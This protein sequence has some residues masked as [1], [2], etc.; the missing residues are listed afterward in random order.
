VWRDPAQHQQG[1]SAALTSSPP[2]NTKQQRISSQLTLFHHYHYTMATST[3]D[4]ISSRADSL[5]RERYSIARDFD[6]VLVIMPSSIITR[7]VNGVF[8]EVKGPPQAAYEFEVNLKALHNM[9][10]FR[11]TI[12]LCENKDKATYSTSELYDDDPRAWRLWLEMLH[13][14]LNHM[15][16]QAQI[17]TVW[18]VLRIADKYDINP[19]CA[20]AGRWFDQWF[21]TQSAS[22]L[23]TNNDAVRQILYPCHAFDHALGFATSTMWLAYH[24]AGHIAEKRPKEFEQHPH[25]GLHRG[26][27][28]MYCGNLQSISSTNRQAEQLNA[29][30][31]RLRSVL[32]RELYD[33]VD[34]LLGRAT[35]S[36]KK[37]V[38]WAY[39]F[40]LNQTRSW[41]LERWAKKYSIQ[42]LLENLEEFEYVDP[43]PN[44]I[45]SD[46]ACGQ[47]FTLVV[48]KAID[49]TGSHFD[50]LCLGKTFFHIHRAY[51]ADCPQTV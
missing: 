7:Y 38:L 6:H 12:P 8:E 33:C 46:R 41:P 35:C 17:V 48:R 31:G 42:Q 2:N 4:A 37:D 19:T 10:Y 18:H 30:R 11:R 21:F 23:F 13:G 29:A 15:S 43:H 45:C 20:D 47:D 1:A 26:I 22:G 5:H 40:A 14:C 28:R 32:H 39:F 3:R 51:H 49:H 9:A 25:L 44:G 16:Y 27:E 34:R 36:L 24:C 50:G